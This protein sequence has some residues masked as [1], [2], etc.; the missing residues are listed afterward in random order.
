MILSALFIPSAFRGFRYLFLTDVPD[1]SV[2]SGMQ[3]DKVSEGVTDGATENRDTGECAVPV[4]SRLD[5]YV[6]DVGQGESVLFISDT[7]ESLLYDCGDYETDTGVYRFLRSHGVDTLD[8]LVLSHYDSDHAGG[9]VY[10]LEHMGVR[11]ILEPYYEQDTKTYAAVMEA[12]AACGADI[13]SP[14]VGDTYPLGTGSFTVVCPVDY[15]Y[16]DVNNNSIGIRVCHD[17]VSI[18]LTG[19]AMRESERDFTDY[20]EEYSVE[21]AS[22]IYVAGHHGSN[23]SSTSRLLELVNPDYVVISVGE[24]NEYGHPMGDCLGRIAR[25]GAELYRTDLQGTLHFIIEDGVLSAD[26]APCNNFSAGTRE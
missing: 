23:T 24:G 2:P 5:I 1:V 20:A 15:S 21:L 4:G 8:Y 18:L 12:Q 26:T 6:L 25:S 13:T 3:T 16:A 9:A 22:D 14:S 17:S 11:T 10:L 7:G 19:D